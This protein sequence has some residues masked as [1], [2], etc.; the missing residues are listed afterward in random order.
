M[1]SVD[2]MTGLSY[3]DERAVASALGRNWWALLILGIVSMIVGAIIIINPGGS[4]WVIAVVL[5]IY[6]LVVIAVCVR[7]SRR[8]PDRSSPGNSAASPPSS[9]ASAVS[10]RSCVGLDSRWYS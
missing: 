3:D 2:P 9:A 7:V 10:R 8:S 1:A 4:T 6:L 5:A